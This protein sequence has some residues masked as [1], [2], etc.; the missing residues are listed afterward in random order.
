[1][2]HHHARRTLR[3]LSGF[4]SVAALA[5]LAGCGQSQNWQSGTPYVSIGGAV[6]G[7]TGT[8]VLSNNGNDSTTLSGNGAFKFGLQIK[9]GAT[10]SVTV[11]TQPKTQT[12]TVSNGSGVATSDVSSVAVSCVDNPTIGGTVS[13]LTGTLVLANNGGD[14]LS[15]TK[16][17]SFTF[18]TALKP[19][20]S[21]SVTVAT[22]PQGQ[23][24]TVTN[25]SGTAAAAVTNIT[26]TC[27]TFTL[28]PLP[29]VYYNG[30]AIN[31][32]PYRSGGPGAGEIVSDAN[33]LQDLGLLHQAGYR[34][35]RLFG[36]D[37]NSNNVLKDAAANFPDLQF[38][39][40]IY[41]EGA[42]SSCVDAVNQSQ[43]TTAIGFANTYPNVAAV[44][45]GNETSFANNL[46]VSC[47]AQYI[48]TVRN[49]I[50]QPV[51]ADD[52]YTFYAGLTAS[53]EKPDSILTLI[54]FA[55]I[56]IYPFSDYGRWNWQQTSVAAGPARAQAMMTASITFAQSALGQVANYLYKGNAGTTTIGASLP[57][58]IGETG[59]KARV[60]NA[61]STIESYAANPV[62]QKWYADLLASWLTQPG[63]PVNIFN[64]EAFDEAWKNVDDGLG[65][66]DA[67]RTPRYALCGTAVPNA[68]TCNNSLYTGAGY[69]Q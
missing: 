57:I 21:Y 36:A 28:R 53:G 29:A 67:S 41:L 2:I 49:Q 24:C 50:Q 65:L 48:S 43:I 55:S 13:G 63:A 22:Q 26:V 7:L 64:F 10:Y 59:W 46:P 54:D 42:P 35:L 23:T 11:I 69:Y 15:L 58:T 52:D 14:A 37:Q 68:P 34:L 3:G 60:T 30:K 6:S 19:N 16:N 18:A 44:S 9:N 1:M 12:C 61:A 33:I 5:V 20:A 47:L 56:H 8:V 17:G 51:T 27:T 31:Y 62:N 45:V 40:G 38:Q 32:S 25:G 39:V 66:W 4:A